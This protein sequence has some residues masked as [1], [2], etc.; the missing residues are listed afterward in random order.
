[1]ISKRNLKDLANK[2][3]LDARVLLS[4]RRYQGCLYLVGYTIELLL[5]YN[6][7]K[8]FKFTRGFPESKIEFSSYQNKVKKRFSTITSIKDFKTHNLQK[9]L[10]YSGKEYDVKAQTLTEWDAVKTW[11]P[12]FRYKNQII[13]KQNA[14]NIVDY[15]ER[16]KK[17]LI[18]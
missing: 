11:D 12:E 15:I 17:I 3:F 6:I 8:I 2:R 5:K 1:M 16:I 13:K 4:K 18:K 10:T 14:I 9:L 7:C